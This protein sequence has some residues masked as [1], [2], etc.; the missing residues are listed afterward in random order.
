MLGHQDGGALVLKTYGHVIP[1]V[2]DRKVAQLR[3]A[4]V[5]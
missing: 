1:T 2:L 4:S 3:I 5:A